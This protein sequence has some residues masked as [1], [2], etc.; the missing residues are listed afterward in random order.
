MIC[1]IS[2]VFTVLLG[3]RYYD[4]PNLHMKRKSRFG[5]NNLPRGTQVE[6]STEMKVCKIPEPSHLITFLRY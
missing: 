2:F 6:K 1:V 5:I 4:Y 3:S